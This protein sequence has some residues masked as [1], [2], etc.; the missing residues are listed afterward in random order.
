MQLAL[1]IASLGC[2]VG[3]GNVLEGVLGGEI[4]GTSQGTAGVNPFP[5]DDTWGDGISADAS[6]WPFPDETGGFDTTAGSDETGVEVTACEETTCN[7]HGT[8]DDS[9]GTATCT[10]NAPYGG[11]YCEFCELT[12]L[13]DDPFNDDNLATGGPESLQAGFVAS[14]N[15]IAQPGVVSE[16]RGFVRIQTPTS[17]DDVDPVLG[18][19]SGHSFDGAAAG[20]VTLVAEVSSSDLPV[21]NG[22]V[23]AFGQAPGLFIDEGTPSHELHIGM[24]EIALITRQS[25]GWLSFGYQGTEYDAEELADGFRLMLSVTPEH[26]AFTIEGLRSDGSRISQTGTWL[27]GVGYEYVFQG[28]DHISFGIHGLATDLL[29]RTLEVDGVAVYEDACEPGDFPS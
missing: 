18:A 26:W 25:G 27:G 4:Q 12:A 15:G 9:S 24:D 1:A 6:G 23:F 2:S 20:G 10:C 11:E 13:L 19:F 21:G 3:S 17:S 8:C 28:S 7:G 5:G 22:I 14:D 29:P 16:Q